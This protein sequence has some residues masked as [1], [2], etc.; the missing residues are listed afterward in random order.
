[1]KHHR[2]PEHHLGRMILSSACGNFIDAAI[3]RLHLGPGISNPGQCNG[4]RSRSGLY[5]IL[6][7]KSSVSIPEIN[8]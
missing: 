1:M 7:M 5:R 6:K 8:R 3:K 4:S 2:I